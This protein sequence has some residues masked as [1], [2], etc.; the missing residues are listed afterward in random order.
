[1]SQRAKLYLER[2]RSE[3]RSVLAYAYIRVYRVMAEESRE[4]I[5]NLSKSCGHVLVEETIDASGGWP[6][7]LLGAAPATPCDGEHRDLAWSRAAVIAMTLGSTL[8]G[9]HA[10]AEG[11][12]RALDRLAISYGAEHVRSLIRAAG[13]WDTGL[14]GDEPLGP[15]RIDPELAG[16]N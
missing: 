7:S 9:L 13:G 10:T 3:Y 15:R 14:M 16:A 11:V 8:R 5:E 2:L 4:V 1:M 6:V 12:R